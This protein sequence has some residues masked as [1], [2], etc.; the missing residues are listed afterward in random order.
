MF[1]ILDMNNVSTIQY[2]LWY[3]QLLSLNIMYLFM[4]LTMDWKQANYTYAIFYNTSSSCLNTGFVTI[5]IWQIPLLEQEQDEH[6]NVKVWTKH[7]LHTK[8]T[9]ILKQSKKRFEMQQQQNP[10]MFQILDMNNVCTIQYHL[11][12]KQLLSLN[13]MY[14]FMR[15]T[16]DWK[17]EHYTYAIFYNTSSSCFITGFVTIVVWR[18][19]LLDQELPTLPEHLGLPAL[20]SAVHVS[21]TFVFCVVFCR[22]L[23]VLLFL[24]YHCFVCTTWWQMLLDLLISV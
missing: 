18:I 21:R 9:G 3:K 10:Q 5:V 8:Q 15:L 13:I 24:F 14:L 16:M 1:Q 17:Q 2:H 11:W 23:F 4:R 7:C 19:P 22:S 12:Y 20:F 6:N